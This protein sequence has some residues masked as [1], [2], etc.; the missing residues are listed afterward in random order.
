VVG[1]G[2]QDDLA[3][4]EE[5]VRDRGTTFT[6]LWDPSFESWANLG[7]ALQPSALL[8]DPD[9][10]LLGRWAGEPPAEEVLDLV[11]GSA[12]PVDRTA[13]SDQFCRFAARYLVADEVLDGADSAPVGE[14]QRIFDDIRFASTA[15]AQTAAPDTQVSA[16]NL[17][18]A[19]A[20]LATVAIDN[21]LD[22]T[23]A[24]SDGYDERR[25]QLDEAAAD[26]ATPVADRCGLVFE[27]E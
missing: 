18:N 5:F 9:G 25:R 16:R 11:R 2:T 14:R 27:V 20:A 23:K 4:A 1:L 22:L 24:R 26:L 19:A 12:G 10:Q 17:A 3:E 21:D 6:M 7:V 8:L 15:M 13:A